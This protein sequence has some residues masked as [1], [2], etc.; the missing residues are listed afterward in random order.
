MRYLNL[1]NV[2]NERTMI[3]YPY[4]WWDAGFN[5]D[6]LKKIIDF[7]ESTGFEKASIL[8]NN[9]P[10]TDE[11]KSIRRCDIKF[12]NR[13]NDTAWIFDR[14]NFIISNL[15]AQFYGFD[16]NGYETFQY[17]SYD[18]SEKGE[19]G[20]HMDICVGNKYLPQN[21]IEPRKLSLTL[22]L[23]EPGKDFEGGE[24]EFN[25]GNP[26]DPMKP[27]VPKGRLIAFPSFMIHRVK[28]VTSGCR[29]SLVV[30]VTG[31][32]FT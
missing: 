2:P 1:F 10:N 21:M 25:G 26:N 30:W 5:D 31:P 24:L 28:P 16:L 8:G 11:V 17:T 27:E 3:T 23:N 14:L 15:N 9:D 19:Y 12:H 7:C 22:L 20:W 6:E 32:K 4:V 18:S 29:K 13:N